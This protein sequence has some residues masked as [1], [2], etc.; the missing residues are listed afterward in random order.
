MGIARKAGTA[1]SNSF[2]HL[3]SWH[4]LSYRNQEKLFKAEQAERD[5][6]KRDEAAAKEFAEQAEFF[7]NTELL[8]AK[9]REG[10]RNKQQLAFMYQKPPGFNAMLERQKQEAAEAAERTAEEKRLAEETEARVAAGLPPLAP[11]EIERRKGRK[12]RKD[13]SGRNILSAAEAPEMAG[14]PRE[15]GAGENAV[16]KPLGKQLRA[17]QCLRCGGFGH[18]SADRECP[19]RDHNPNDAFRAKLEDPLTL[20]RARG[21]LSEGSRKFELKTP[22][23]TS[24][25]SPTR[26]G[27]DPGAANQQLLYDI[28]GEEVMEEMERDARRGGILE[29]LPKSERKRLIR[30]YREREKEAKRAK[31]VAA[32]E[33]LRSQGIASGEKKRSKEEKKDKRDR[34]RGR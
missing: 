5:R 34:K 2:L 19:M 17:V 29:T 13:E 7:K 6:K 4:P 25:L 10:L 3:K 28:D 27:V 30:E 11:E 20:M 1:W 32:E 33:F 21:A 8:S 23:T 31:V 18:T 15:R 16:V 14:A 12:M 22:M 9:D 26:G 24:G